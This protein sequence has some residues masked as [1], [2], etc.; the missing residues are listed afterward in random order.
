MRILQ[1]SGVYTADP[2]AKYTGIAGYKRLDIYA[3]VNLAYSRRD[4]VYD[5]GAGGND[6]L[7]HAKAI[8]LNS[9]G[10]GGVSNCKLLIHDHD[11][12]SF[13][14][15]SAATY[16]LKAGYTAQLLNASGAVIA[17]VGSAGLTTNL[18]AGKYYFHLYNPTKSLSGT[19][20]L[21]VTREA[22][23]APATAKPAYSSP[24][25]TN[26]QPPSAFIKND[27]TMVYA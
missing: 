14:V 5:Q 8:P 13:N 25:S 18:G 20:S 27:P 2:D 26:A 9:A 10:S 12:F 22:T 4:D 7:A 1:D 11:Y 21:T 15:A 23:I 6:D 3:A 16:T 19:Y 17:T 24:F